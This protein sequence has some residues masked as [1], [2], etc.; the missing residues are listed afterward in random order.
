MK[1]LVVEL[2]LIILGVVATRIAFSSH[3]KSETAALKHAPLFVGFVVAAFFY[4]SWATTGLDPIQRVICL[5]APGAAT[6]SSTAGKPANTPAPAAAGSPAVS[7]PVQSARPMPDAARSTTAGEMAPSPS[8][9]NSR[10][11]QARQS[12]CEQA[13]GADP[14]KPGLNQPGNNLERATPQAIRWTLCRSQCVEEKIRCA[15]LL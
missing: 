3:Y 7:P 8:I 4:Y 14:R 13:C 6:C 2:V 11:C 9:Q 1:S 5:V 15:G 12:A 10:V